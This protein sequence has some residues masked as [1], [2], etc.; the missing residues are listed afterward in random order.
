MYDEEIWMVL[1]ALYRQGWTKSALAREFGLNRRTVNRY[2]ESDDAPTYGPRSCPRELAADQLAHVTRRLASCPSIRTTTLFREVRE[3]GYE[4]SYA[5]FNRRVAKLRSEEAAEPVVR[6][7]TEPGIQTQM[8]W[9]E[10]GPWP[11]GEETLDLK[12]LVGVLGYSRVVAFRFATDKTRATTLRL[13]TSVLGGLGGVTTEILTDRDPAFVVGQT[14]DGKA[15]LA[16]EWVDL[17]ARLGVI[18]KACRPYR[19][20]T[21]GKVER[22]IREIK[23][24]F[25]PWL[26]GQALPPR[27][28]I[29]DYDA[30]AAK[31]VNEV[32]LPRRHRTTGMVVAEAWVAEQAKLTSIPE[33]LVAD[34][35]GEVVEAT[36]IE[37]TRLKAE[38]AVVEHRPLSAYDRMAR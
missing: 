35:E 20:K 17:T 22:V 9:A 37:L 10:M 21:K 6:F 36:V 28:T 15:I 34:V 32:V 4:G 19:A 5:S 29:A 8:D 24:D 27:P 31:W 16:P 33:R 3:F 7:E 2:I 13:T 25:V 30:L 1:R 18:A 14:S 26:T 38:G 11:L 12:V 23:E